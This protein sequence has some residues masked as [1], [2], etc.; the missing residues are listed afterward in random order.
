VNKTFGIS[1][2][3][4]NILGLMDLVATLPASSANA[5]QGFSIMKQAKN[6]WRSRLLSDKMTEIMRVKI[7]SPSINEF[8]PL[9][10]IH[11]WNSS[12][13]RGRRMNQQPYDE[14]E[15]EEEEELSEYSEMESDYELEPEDK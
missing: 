5:E 15:L 6:D 10:A 8:D 3:L 1:D 9:S 7:H 2:N 14:R 4:E 11:L 13:T 12:S